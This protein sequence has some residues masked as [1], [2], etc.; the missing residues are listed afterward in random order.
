MNH[1][2]VA[3]TLEQMNA[4]HHRGERIIYVGT[5]LRL[6]MRRVHLVKQPIEPLPL[7]A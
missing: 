2:R 6:R 7:L 3:D 5:E 4:V 1:G